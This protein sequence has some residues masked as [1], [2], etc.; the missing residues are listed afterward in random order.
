MVRKKVEAPALPRPLTMELTPE[1]LE[2]GDELTFATTHF[3]PAALETL[4]DQLRTAV[5]AQSER[6][7]TALERADKH[8]VGRVS[9]AE[10]HRA[11]GLLGLESAPEDVAALFSL[12]QPDEND[13]IA[14]VEL[15]E[16]IV[17]ST[18]SHPRLEPARPP[19]TREPPPPPETVEDP[20]TSDMRT[21]ADG[22]FPVSEQLRSILH[23]NLLPLRELFRQRDEAMSGEVW[24]LE[25]SRAMHDLG[26]DADESSIGT[27][28]S[29][30]DLNGSGAIDYNK[31]ARLLRKSIAVYPR[32][33]ERLEAGG[34]GLLASAENRAQPNSS[35]EHDVNDAVPL[36]H[37]PRAS[38]SLGRVRTDNHSEY[39]DA[40]AKPKA[41]DF[42]YPRPYR[43]ARPVSAP[44]RL[45][46]PSDS[47]NGRYTEA[48]RPASKRIEL[49][50]EKLEL[51]TRRNDKFAV[52]EML[53]GN[54][55]AY[56]SASK[57]AIVVLP[58][59][60]AGKEG[61]KFDLRVRT[62]PL[63]RHLLHAG[64]SVL[65]VQSYIFGAETNVPQESEKLI[66]V[67][68]HVK[69]HR[70]FK[71]CKVAW[72]TQGMVSLALF[73]TFHKDRAVF[74]PHSRVVTAC[75]LPADL[76]NES[77]AAIRECS[78]PVLVLC[79]PGADRLAAEHTFSP[80]QPDF[81]EPI[82]AVSADDPRAPAEQLLG[83][84]E[85]KVG[86][87]IEMLNA[88][89]VEGCGAVDA[90]GFVDGLLRVGL[91]ASEEDVGALFAS[92]E[93]NANGLL[94]YKNMSQIL[95]AAKG[96]GAAGEAESLDASDDLV[97]A[98]IDVED[99]LLYGPREDF[100]PSSYLGDRPQHLLAFLQEHIAVDPHRKYV[101]KAIRETREA[102][103]A[104]RVLPEPEPEPEVLNASLGKGGR[105]RAK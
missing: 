64:W 52:W 101:L 7:I 83:A 85:G 22:L 69:K 29:S 90:K 26:V 15:A 88:V 72:L 81:P 21:D 17:R 36:S 55:G 39:L 73:T 2:P 70:H 51:R 103:N 95:S 14:Y 89:D 25:F 68:E 1:T 35:S 62:A 45:T 71:Y 11:L 41:Y 60:H 58:M 102:D 33:P 67:M 38:T 66:A 16:R 37:P 20:R 43:S 99:S 91:R 13:T 74:M 79:K 56:R 87:L 10:F 100:D 12:L 32:L 80:P 65:V 76:S 42:S 34:G 8:A 75:Q 94:E 47:Q 3:D 54:T 82:D 5:F 31:L 96:G 19:A 6:V 46:M 78:L 61:K 50:F 59:T 97:R 23:R 104:V 44:T 27:L 48:S 86:R 105:N 77:Y 28:F 30:L 93:L 18:R 84:L 40:G 92:I 24:K 63:H 49:P 9:G 53:G 98:Y 57:L 4:P